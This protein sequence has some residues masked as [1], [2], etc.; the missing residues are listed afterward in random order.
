MFMWEKVPGSPCFS[1]LQAMKTGWDLGTRLGKMH[2]GTYKIVDPMNTLRAF[3][4][5]LAGFSSPTQLCWQQNGHV[6]PLPLAHLDAVHQHESS[7]VV[8]GWAP[9]WRNFLHWWKAAK[10]WREMC[11]LQL[12]GEWRTWM[13]TWQTEHTVTVCLFGSMVQLVVFVSAMS[14]FT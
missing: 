7:S 13:M 5:C 10:K 14:V 3:T 2:V 9:Q 8:A 12:H 1:I 6:W 4:S 11:G